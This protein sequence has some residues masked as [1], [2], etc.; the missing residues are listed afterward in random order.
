[1]RKASATT[2]ISLNGQ[3]YKL[4]DVQDGKLVEREVPMLNAMN[5]VLR[6]DYIKDSV[7]GVAAGT[8]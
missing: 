8:R 6:D 2:I 3:S 1:M 5:E 7:A 4:L